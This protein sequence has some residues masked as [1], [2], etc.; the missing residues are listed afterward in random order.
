MAVDVLQHDDEVIDQ[1]ADGESD[2]RQAGHVQRAAHQPII[3]NM[4]TMLTA[5]ETKTTTDERKLRK[6]SIS[7]RTV[8]TPPSKM[9]SHTRSIDGVDV[10]RLVVDLRQLQPLGREHARR[11]ARRRPCVSS[12]CTS[13][14]VGAR[15][16]QTVD[17]DHRR[18]E[19]PHDA[20]GLLV[21]E[22]HLGH[23]A[24]VDRRARRRAR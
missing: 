17:G 11:S 21:A 13:Q 18:A 1:H 16:A 14:H 9:L 23:V 24:N 10:L 19:A 6:N 15:A 4:P 8:S 3:R 20:V 2:A 5:I 22:L 7:T 12:S